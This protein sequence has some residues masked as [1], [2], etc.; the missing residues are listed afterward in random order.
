MPSELKNPMRFSIRHRDIDL[1]QYGVRVTD[2]EV[3]P[4][5]GQVY[6]HWDAATDQEW[7]ADVLDRLNEA[8]RLLEANEEAELAD[9]VGALYQRVGAAIMEDEHDA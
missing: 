6:V 5:E 1:E 8:A 7:E 3:R 4:S 9:A 2:I